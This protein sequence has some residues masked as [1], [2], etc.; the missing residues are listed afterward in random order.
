MVMNT[1]FVEKQS[2]AVNKQELLELAEKACN[3]FD[4]YAQIGSSHYAFVD[5]TKYNVEVK[6]V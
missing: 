6:D 5:T 2:T 4:G 1:K 3:K